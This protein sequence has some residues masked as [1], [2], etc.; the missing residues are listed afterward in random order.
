[1]ERKLMQ[2]LYPF[3]ALE[4]DYYMG[5]EATGGGC[6]AERDSEEE[7]SSDDELQRELCKLAGIKKDCVSKRRKGKENRSQFEMDMECELDQLI[8]DYA[9]EYLSGN[10]KRPSVPTIS[11]QEVRVSD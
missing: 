10:V 2:K 8:T 7:L 4:K 11:C 9:N 3:E 5:E 6:D 1:M